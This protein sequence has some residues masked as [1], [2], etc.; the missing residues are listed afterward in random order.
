MKNE[1]N[2]MI[3]WEFKLPEEVQLKHR[4]WI[5]NPFPVKIIEVGRV[6]N[7]RSWIVVGI[8]TDHNPNDNPK[9]YR[10]IFPSYFNFN[11][12]NSKE[13]LIMTI[14]DNKIVFKSF[15]EDN[16]EDDLPF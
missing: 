3:V 10:I 4:E 15:K 1:R 11:F 5:S 16:K 13:N 7:T 8:P 9:I 14:E 2:E 12:P 6:P